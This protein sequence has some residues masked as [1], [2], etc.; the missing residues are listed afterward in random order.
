MIIIFILYQVL[1]VDDEQQVIVAGFTFVKNIDLVKLWLEA[2][3]GCLSENRCLKTIN[4]Y[5]KSNQIPLKM[6]K[7]E[8]IINN[9]ASL[10]P[11]TL[12]KMNS[13][14]NLS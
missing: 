10:Q 13:L 9:T 2:V 12:L 1:A 8:I 7:K 11:T 3:A 5:L 6:N 4:N 14:M